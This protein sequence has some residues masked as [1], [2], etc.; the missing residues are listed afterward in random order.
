MVLIRLKSLKERSFEWLQLAKR[1]KMFSCRLSEE[2]Y[3]K[4]ID[5]L[6]IC[7]SSSY[8]FVQNKFR[9]FIKVLHG[10]LYTNHFGYLRLKPVEGEIDRKGL[11]ALKKASQQSMYEML[12]S[13]W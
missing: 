9:H 8:E 4:L 10:R 3:E 6:N 1:D 11:E 13:A 7:E 5:L 12:F 2:E